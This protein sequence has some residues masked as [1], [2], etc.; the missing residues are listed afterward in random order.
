MTSPPDPHDSH[1][2]G[3]DD[4]TQEPDSPEDAELRAR[5]ERALDLTREFLT[6]EELDEQRRMLFSLARTSPGLSSWLRDQRPRAVP[7][8]SGLVQKKDEEA[9]R[10]AAARRAGGGGKRA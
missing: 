7:D 9:M 6:P 1:A 4:P 5:V 8:E 10:A 2:P 3:Q